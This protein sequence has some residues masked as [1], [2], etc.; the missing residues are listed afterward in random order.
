[1]VIGD[2]EG[3]GPKRSSKSWSPEAGDPVPPPESVAQSQ[4]HK[5]A[6]PCRR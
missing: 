3:K 5:A 2:W 1:M 4:Q 6:K